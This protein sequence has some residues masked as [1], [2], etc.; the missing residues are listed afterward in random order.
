MA[1]WYSLWSFGIF[2]YVWTTKNLATLVVN[3][4]LRRASFKQHLRHTYVGSSGWVIKV[5][6]SN[7]EHKV[8]GSS[9]DYLLYVC[10]LVKHS[11]NDKILQ[12]VIKL[13]YIDSYKR[14]ILKIHLKI[15]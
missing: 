12:Y 4:F 3:L 9:L 5:S 8:Y 2:W 1:V 10:R 15:L 11:I 13:L 7:P 14:K 6:P